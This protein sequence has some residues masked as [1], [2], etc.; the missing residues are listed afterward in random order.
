MDADS[1]PILGR[2]ALLGLAGWLARRESDA[3]ADRNADMD[4]AAAASAAHSG[5]PPEPDRLPPVA[6]ASTVEGGRS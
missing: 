6:S 1:A 4:R 2:E 3:S 5:V